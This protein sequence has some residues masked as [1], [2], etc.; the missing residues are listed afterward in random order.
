MIESFDMQANS[1]NR[2]VMIVP[3]LLLLLAAFWYWSPLLALRQLQTAAKEMDAAAFN[4]RVDYPRLRESVKASILA[5][6]GGQRDQGD[7]VAMVGRVIGDALVGR[8][9]DGLVQP[10]I[11]M[12][13]MNHGK[14]NTGR[15]QGEAE[16]DAEAGAAEKDWVGEREG[17]NTYIAYIGN[18]GEPNEQR[19]GLV[20]VR[21]GFATWRLAGLRLPAGA[22][23]PTPAS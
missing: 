8:L 5:R 3:V 7:M 12:R 16:A 2:L 15:D 13:M 1:N 9:V 4:E 17:V 20:M 22:P 21:S 6:D 10:D 11:V 18:K 19:L 14:F 23:V